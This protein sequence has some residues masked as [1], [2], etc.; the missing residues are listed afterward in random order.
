MIQV[1]CSRLFV[2]GVCA[3]LVAGCGGSG[4]SNGGG[5]GGGT[6]GGGGN[7]DTTVTITFYGPSQPSVVDAQIGTSAFAAE[8]LSG[9]ILTL[10]IPSGT[11]NYS[12][13]YLCPAL[14]TG[15]TSAQ[16]EYL[17]EA[18]IVDGT[19]LTFSCAAQPSL[20]PTLTGSLD[21]TAI[22]GVQQFQINARN[23]ASFNGGYANGPT[24]SFNVPAPA[25][26]DRVLVQAYTN[27][28]QGPVAAKNFDN[29]TVPGALN[30][31]NT[32]VF[33]TADKTTPEA[34]TYNNV[35]AA[36]ASPNTSIQLGMNGTSQ[37][38][39]YASDATTQYLALPAS[40]TEDGDVYFLDA[41]ASSASIPSSVNTLTISSGGPV[42]FTFP[43]PWS[44]A[45][46][47]PAA[48]PSFTM[49]YTGFA[50]QANVTQN[51]W[52]FWGSG[53]GGGSSSTNNIQV[54]A[55]AN[56]QAGSTTLAIPD[57]SGLQGFFAAPA[58][59]KQVEWVVSMEQQS[60]SLTAEPSLN[61]TAN[62]VMNSGLYTVP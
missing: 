45:G 17:W 12:V 39:Y 3:A 18:S 46:P 43:A 32:V 28:N 36:F 56:Y 16:F 15:G 2:L 14:V 7:S 50:G 52:I 62:E 59:G 13:V 54:A 27:Q 42:T 53:S 19:S 49:G 23:A 26:S 48:L 22:A 51:V 30:G 9:N 6:G 29:Q 60:W 1:N 58:S 37:A 11:S 20:T 4:S 41:S 33:G 10:T 31:G 21:A 24:S 34:I 5:G 25:G 44:Y 8:T 35:P 61:S 40:A 47:T 57:L 55:T 38:Y